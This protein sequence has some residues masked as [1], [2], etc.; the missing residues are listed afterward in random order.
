MAA[1]SG[2]L[3]YIRGGEQLIWD[4]AWRSESP[5]SRRGEIKALN[6]SVGRTMDVLYGGL[7]ILFDVL[8]IVY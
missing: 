6:T 3:V 5:G 2:P 7:R 1:L 4:G 8:T